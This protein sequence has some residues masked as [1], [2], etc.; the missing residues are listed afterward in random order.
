MNE[1]KLCKD[2]KWARRSMFHWSKYAL[3]RAP[4][5]VG[6]SLVTGKAGRDDGKFCDQQR[7]WEECCGRDAKWFT[8]R[9]E[10]NP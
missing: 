8:P 6:V 1:P 7:K 2:C 9:K 10:P 3:C 4:Q 5:A